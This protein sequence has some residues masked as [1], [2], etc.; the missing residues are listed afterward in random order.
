MI[1]SRKETHLFV[2]L[3]SNTHHSPSSLRTHVFDRIFI[4][5]AYR[6]GSAAI[7]LVRESGKTVA[8]ELWKNRKIK[9]HFANSIIEGDY[10]YG[11][12]GMGSTRFFCMNLD[13]GKILW[14]E[15]G[16]STPHVIFAPDCAILL[17]GNGNLALATIGPEGMEVR[18]K[19]RIAERYSFSAPTLVDS[20][21]YV[22]DRKHIMAFD[23]R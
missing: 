16:F 10:V 8:S 7:R 21:L 2:E 19:C 18:A 4:S 20:K 15:R 5:S 12:T 22:R 1:I 13:T 6:T 17:D 9:V 14:R 23:L 3:Q 11:S